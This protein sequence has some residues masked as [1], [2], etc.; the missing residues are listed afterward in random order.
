MHAQV[1]SVCDALL[2]QVIALLEPR[3]LTTPLQQMA[4]AMWAA[5]EQ[6]GMM[7]M[8]TIPCSRFRLSPA[9]QLMVC[10]ATQRSRRTQ[11]SRDSM[12]FW[13]TTTG[14]NATGMSRLTYFGSWR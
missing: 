8:H 3:P 7:K 14:R 10:M 4:L 5:I 9:A 13:W 11:H 6:N 2:A 12:G 1:A